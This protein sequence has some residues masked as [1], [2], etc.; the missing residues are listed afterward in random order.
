MKKCTV[1]LFV[2]G[3]L[4]CFLLGCQKKERFT[5][6]TVTSTVSPSTV[7]LAADETQKFTATIKNSKGTVLDVPPTWMVN[8]GIGT[9][10]PAEG[11]YTIFTATASGGGSVVAFIDGIT[12]SAAVTVTGGASTGRI[13]YDDDW[14]EC[15]VDGFMGPSNGASLTVNSVTT[16]PAYGTSCYEI[17]YNKAAETWAGIAFH[18]SGTW[19][20]EGDK[21]LSGYTKF[22]FQAK[23]AS[24]NTKVSFYVGCGSDAPSA[25]DTGGAD[26]TPKPATLTTSWQEFTIYL[27]GQNLSEINTLFAFVIAEGD[28][29]GIA[30]PVTFYIDELRY[31]N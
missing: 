23:A 16:S 14:N 27:T 7:A 29:P 15:F 19:G 13:V 8:G 11:A 12:A 22:S 9:V 3:F 21:N 10:S 31:H 6:S 18:Y 20:G 26:L 17:A 30:S 4:I 5:V 25:T 1:P 24:N 2:M 28:N